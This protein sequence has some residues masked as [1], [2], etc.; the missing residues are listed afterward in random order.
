M[1]ITAPPLD[2]KTGTGAV[3]RRLPSL[4]CL[5]A[6]LPSNLAALLRLH[7]DVAVHHLTP[8]VVALEGEGAVADLAARE[9]AVLPVVGLCP[10]G[11]RLAVD[12]DL[13][14]VALDDDFVGEPLVVADWR[15]VHDVLHRVQ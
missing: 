13:D 5:S 6:K 11:G 9:L 3:T 10:I 15:R 1:G 8:G 14:V 12:L 7:L 4:N 2:Q